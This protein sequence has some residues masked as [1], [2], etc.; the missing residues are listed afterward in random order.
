M[1]ALE[2]LIA[3]LIVLWLVGGVAFPIG[4]SAV[5]LILVLVLVLVVVKVVRG[6]R[7]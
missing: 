3:V 5:H 4:T 1:G 6:E 7:L 2:L